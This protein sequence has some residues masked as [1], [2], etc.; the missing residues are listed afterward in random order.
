[1]D[2]QILDLKGDGTMTATEARSTVGKILIA[3]GYTVR[4]NVITKKGSKTKITVL[5]Y[6]KE[7]K[8]N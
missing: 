5:E 1:M 3:S 6:W 7:E 4:Q 8:E 2:K